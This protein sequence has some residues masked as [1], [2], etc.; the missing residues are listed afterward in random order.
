MSLSLTKMDLQFQASKMP[1]DSEAILFRCGEP[2]NLQGHREERVLAYQ[3]NSAL[4]SANFMNKTIL[5]SAKIVRVYCIY[6]QRNEWTSWNG[7]TAITHRPCGSICLTEDDATAQAERFRSPGTILSIQDTIGIALCFDG[8]ALII[9]E[10]FSKQPF[11]NLKPALP[12]RANKPQLSKLLEAVPKVKFRNQVVLSG[13]SKELEA[14]KQDDVFYE[15]WA[16]SG[17]KKN[18]LAWN[19]KPYQLDS[20]SAL[21]FVS[22][23]EFD[24][25]TPQTRRMIVSPEIAK[26]TDA[27]NPQPPALSALAQLQDIETEKEQLTLAR[28][29]QGLYRQR[30]E[31]IEPRCRVTGLSKKGHLVASHI[32]PWRDSTD[33]EKLDGNNGLLLSPHIDHLFDRGFISFSDKG[34][35]LVSTELDE[36]VLAA[37]RIDCKVSIGDF[38]LEQ[39]RYMAYHRQ[40]IFKG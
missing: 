17:G 9:F 22:S 31:A 1:H 32:K 23:I 30:L 7:D 13:L 8:G 18:G 16:K 38:N 39:S 34:S 37:W 24:S 2:F 29:G 12:S 14:C 40:C 35:V 5:H 26:A 33:Q 25:G 27:V 15:R 19:L 10:Y 4:N 6:Q 36:E 21:A 3:I 28:R 20:S 11:Q